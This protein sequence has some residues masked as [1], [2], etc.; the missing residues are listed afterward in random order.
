MKEQRFQ[1]IM[2]QD[3]DQKRKFMERQ[4]ELLERRDD[5]SNSKG[6]VRRQDGTQGDIE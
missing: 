5:L 4:M 6:A 2:Q 3:S 1:S